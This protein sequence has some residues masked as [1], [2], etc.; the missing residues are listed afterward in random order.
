MP[1]WYNSGIAG[2]VTINKN[3]GANGKDMKAYTDSNNFND[4]YY[5]TGTN[6][7]SLDFGI[8]FLVP[9]NAG[10]YDGFAGEAWAN[11]KVG[12]D[13]G[14]PETT[15][16]LTNKASIKC[17]WKDPGAHTYDLNGTADFTPLP[18]TTDDWLL[19]QT[20]TA[21]DDSDPT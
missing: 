4:G 12:G 17:T 21:P 5:L 20:G 16:P 1:H 9:S 13:S 3:L 14:S 2:D 8:F 6:R 10:T 18:D 15:Y 19:V 11:V 7:E